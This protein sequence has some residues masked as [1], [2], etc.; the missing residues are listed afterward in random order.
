MKGEQWFASSKTGHC[1]GHKM[2]ELLFNK[3]FWQYPVCHVEHGRDINAAI[4]IQRKDI[5]ELQ[6]AGLV[7]SAHGGHRQSVIKTVAA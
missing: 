3:R 6:A 5:A 7:V 2:A 4:S 1:C